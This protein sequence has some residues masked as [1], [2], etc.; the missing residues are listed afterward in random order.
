MPLPRG[1]VTFLF[2]DIESSTELLARLGDAYGQVLADHR[3]AIRSAVQEAHGTEVD[4]RGDEFF[5]VFPDARGAVEAAAQAQRSHIDGVRI[6]IGIHCGTAAVSDGTYF[7]IDVHR[8]ARICSAAHGGQ[9][10]L[11]EAA[12]A[13]AGA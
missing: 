2:T 8:A 13:A 5:A 7:G 12:K 10:L 9:V 6:R 1:N 4:A 3:A 11:S